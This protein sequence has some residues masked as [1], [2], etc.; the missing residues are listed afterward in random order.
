[1]FGETR[2]S[3]A[4]LRVLGWVHSE[5]EGTWGLERLMTL[6]QQLVKKG[7]SGDG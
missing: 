5:A 4:K 7:G 2:V 1:M 3:L 6:Y